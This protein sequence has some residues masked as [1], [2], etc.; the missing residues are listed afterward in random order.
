MS[1]GRFARRIISLDRLIKSLLVLEGKVDGNQQ[2][3]VLERLARAQEN[4]DDFVAARAGLRNLILR[5]NN[6]PVRTARLRR[7][8]IQ[9]YIGSGL[10]AD[11]DAASVRY[12]E[13]YLPDDTEWNLL[14]GQILIEN[15]RTVEGCN[16]IGRIARS[17]GEAHAGISSSVRRFAAA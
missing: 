3:E 5:V 10:V 14:R 2:L 16:T 15:E 11:A 4:N 17:E 6:D 13:E 9:N 1:Y 7:L 8:L 12:Q